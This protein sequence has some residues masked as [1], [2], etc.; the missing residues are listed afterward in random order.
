MGRSRKRSG[1]A[2]KPT[3][4]PIP[5]RALPALFFVSGAAALVLQVVWTRWL[6]LALGASTRATTV[7]LATFMAGLGI[8]SWLAGRLADRRPASTVRLFAAV[9]AG[10][11]LWA[12]LSIA[13]A[14]RW[15]PEWSAA[16]ARALDAP[17]LPVAARVAL[18]V[19]V[20]L[21]PTAM[22]GA[23]L[24][25][26]ARWAV[27]A[28]LLPG[29]GVGTLYTVNTFG[30]VV[31]VLG[32][33][34]L[35]IEA[36]G[37]AGAAA[38]AGVCDLAIA[39]VAIAIARRSRPATDPDV[40]AAR[41]RAS[42]PAEPPT[43][44]V[45]T[46]DGVVRRAFA[47]AIA[48]YFVSGF[49]GLALEVVTF[50]MLAVLSGSSVYAFTV[51]LAAFLTGIAGGSALAA[52]IAD[53]ERHPV[54]AVGI[55]LGVLATGIG[56][57][58][59]VTQAGGWEAIGRIA[60]GVPGF[61]GFSYGFELAAYLVVLLPATLALGAVVPLIA[62][63]AAAVPARTGTRFGAAYALNTAGA[64]LGATLGG[65]VL[66]PTLGTA[67]AL[68]ALAAVAGVTGLAVIATAVPAP[69]R[70][71]P[72][73]IAA[74]TAV[75]GI[76]LT[77]AGDP[78]RY[79]LGELFPRKEPVFFEEG[80][81]Q[82]VAV[83][84]IED[85]AQLPYLRMITNRTS[86]TG[87]NLYSKRYM[88]LLGHLPA[89]WGGPAHEAL[90]ICFG[91]GMTAGAVASHD[92][93]ER[94]DIAEIS[95]EVIAAADHFRDV[96]H[97]VLDDERV[98]LHVEDGRHVLL[99]GGPWDLVT[100]EPPPPRDSGVVS[101]YSTEF[102]ELSARRLAPDGVFAQWIPLHSQSGDEIRMLVRSFLDGYEHVLGLLPV[103]RDLLLLG[104]HER[105]RVDPAELA[106]RMRDPRAAASLAETGFTH[107]A[108]LLATVVADRKALER[109]AGDAPAVTDDRPRVEYFVRYGKR[110]VRPDVRALAS[111]PPRLETLVTGRIDAALR[112]RFDAARVALLGVL[113]G[114]Y[115]RE[116]GALDDAEAGALGA[117]A[118]RPTDPYYLWN[119]RLSD[120]HIERLER[121]AEQSRSNEAWVE[122]GGRWAQRD[123]MDRALAAFRSAL[124]I[125]PDDPEALLRVGMLELRGD[126]ATAASG[127]ARLRRFLEVAPGHPA[128]RD[129]RRM[130]P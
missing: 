80:P 94:L 101:L 50:R 59:V 108:D 25:L 96:N 37:L 70:M 119:A 32:A 14:G 58:V 28:D 56:F 100:L 57:L 41:V 129:V 15:L 20:L 71:R 12:L 66:V 123:R 36:T 120:E 117:L 22:M 9:E 26:L 29:R 116:A 46:G 49:V 76:A 40:S 45:D 114:A 78:V 27:A 30:G 75:A 21:P 103:E 34:F 91:T 19:A 65:L 10:I 98:R 105:L 95:P 67:R 7:V 74:L 104:S 16:L 3:G 39:G 54:A 83:Y 112:D 13:L 113:R 47:I 79:S 42:V 24:P 102:Y 111:N 73:S 85:D 87:T 64:V 72:L 31:G 62:R 99:A 38:V 63:I 92:A 17:T 130:L 1:A 51:M 48:A 6:T 52:R 23:T 90:V 5:R 35:L 128:A 33:T 107:P 124:D 89:L 109:F 127:R 53:R 68:T 97:S 125:A 77:F 81:V 110:P 60:S 2:A 44:K 126:G 8:G 43:A 82:T 115:A 61:S 106:R 84:A 86:L 18:A 11:G 121:R 122:A 88:T 55:T 69:A 93:I 118:L 4:G